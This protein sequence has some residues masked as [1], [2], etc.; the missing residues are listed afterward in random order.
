MLGSEFKI[1]YS[2][3]EEGMVSK[4]AEQLYYEDLNLLNNI[5]ENSIEFRTM[6]IY[7]ILDSVEVK[8]FIINSTEQNINFKY[9][10]LSIVNEDN[11]TIA[12]ENIGLMDAGEIPPM[13]VRP[14]SIYFSKNNLTNGKK[15]NDKCKLKVDIDRE[16][17]HFSEKTILNYMDDN[18]EIY[19]KRIIEKYIDDMDPII[20]NTFRIEPYKSATDNEGNAYSI[21]I[22]TNGY[23]KDISLGEFTII[24]KDH[25]GIIQATKKVSNLPQIIGKTTSVFKIIIKPEDILKDDFNPEFSTSTIV[26]Q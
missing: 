9:L 8:V 15:I 14:Y 10:N 6:Y 7:D 24:Y 5:K 1:S 4:L 18:I 20:K 16:E 11:E 12:R 19:E 13:N 2:P 21:I 26:F 17:K 25:I 3:K 22:I 23:S